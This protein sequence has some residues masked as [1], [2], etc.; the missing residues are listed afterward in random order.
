MSTLNSI[1]AERGAAPP[2]GGAGRTLG[3]VRYLASH[4]ERPVIVIPPQGAAYRTS[5]AYADR[6]ILVESLR[7]L[8]ETLSLEE[9]AVVL[10]ERPTAV[11]DLYDDGAV[12]SLYYAETERLI[13]A[14]TGATRVFTFDHTR[15]V[16]GDAALEARAGRAPVRTVHNDYTDR[17]APQRVRDLLGAEA[18]TLLRGRFAIMNTWR[19]IRGPV[20]RLPLGFLHPASVAPEDL[21]LAEMRYRDRTGEIYEIAHSPAHRWLYVPE[22][23]REEVLLFKCYDSARDGR[24]RFLPHT[25]FDDAATAADAP[26]RESIETR[27]LVFF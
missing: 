24:A 18:E 9:D 2:A 21:I 10:R 13:K 8:A 11:A 16:E 6:E 14:E 22:M 20:R 25:G 3:T 7:P 12:E 19:P 26:P 4:R 17:S 27:S 15:R 5:A 1:T 23:R